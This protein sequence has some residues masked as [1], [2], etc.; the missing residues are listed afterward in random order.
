VHFG[1]GHGI[2]KEWK[3]HEIRYFPGAIPLTLS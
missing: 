3:A 1:V 2:S